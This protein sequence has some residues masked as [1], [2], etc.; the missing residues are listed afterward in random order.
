[1]LICLTKNVDQL[2]LASQKQQWSARQLI[3]VRYLISNNSDIYYLLVP[4]SP[5]IVWENCL[6]IK[7]ST[8]CFETRTTSQKQLVRWSHVRYLM[9]Y[10]MYWKRLLTVKSFD[11]HRLSYESNFSKIKISISCFQRR[12]TSSRIG[13]LIATLRVFETTAVSAF[14]ASWRL[15]SEKRKI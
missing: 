13:L 14:V 8:S 3:K 7:M 1:M 11:S 15:S 6:N 2:F 12:T 4:C 10:N 9:G 5:P